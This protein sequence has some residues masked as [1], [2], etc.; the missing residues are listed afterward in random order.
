MASFVHLDDS[1][2]NREA[3][4]LADALVTVGIVSETPSLHY[5]VA[6][7][8]LEPFDIGS[9]RVCFGAATGPLGKGDVA[10]SP[11]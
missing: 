6:A 4:L 10:E 9:T 1:D 8:A 2:W 11:G 3:P 5:T 7:S